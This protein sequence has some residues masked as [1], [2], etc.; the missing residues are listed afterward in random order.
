MESLAR[1]WGFLKQSWQMVKADRDLIKPSIYALFSG[2]IVTIIFIIPM[3]ITG[4]LF[5]GNNSSIGTYVMIFM[6]ALLVFVQS[7]VSYIFSAMTI[8]LIY[9][10]LSEGDGR[11]DKAWAII[12]RDWLDILSLAAATAFINFIKGFIKGKGKNKGRNFLSNL[13]DTV[14]MEAAF[15]I[16]PSMV[17]EDK[18]LKN[19]LARAGEIIK[20]NLLLV[21]ISTVGIKAVNAFINIILGL[22]GL[23]LGFGFGYGI[24]TLSGAST[25]GWVSGIS[26]G[27]FF[28]AI[29]FMIAAVIST[30]S[31]TAYHTCLYLWACDIEK[32]GEGAQVSAPSPLAAVLSD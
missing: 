32:A 10:Y 30:Y 11:M 24:I 14:W 4:F 28:A 9:G 21:G 20:N 16:L 15:L 8:Y 3:A 1:G 5:G 31:S 29:F 17:I 25:F 6:G 27:V 13:I 26:I 19:G 18:N 2:F 22:F 23:S 7:S 12:K